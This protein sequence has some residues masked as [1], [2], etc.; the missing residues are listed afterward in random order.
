MISLVSTCS[1]KSEAQERKQ[2]MINSKHSGRSA[3]ELAKLTGR[4]L[5]LHRL[6]QVLKV[7]NTFPKTVSTNLKLRS[8]VRQTV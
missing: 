1:S 7:Y 5:P 8:K 4:S 6:I 2:I 3:V